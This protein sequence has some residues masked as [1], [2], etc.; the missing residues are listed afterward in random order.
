MDGK[1]QIVC[2]YTHTCICIY[3]CMYACIYVYVYIY[4]C[5]YAVIS[6]WVV[7]KIGAQEYH[8]DLV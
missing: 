5:M 8:P 3:I 1:K 7:V 4:V 6:I 2:V